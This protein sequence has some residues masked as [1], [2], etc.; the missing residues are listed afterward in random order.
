MDAQGVLL[1]HEYKI[2]IMDSELF[3]AALSSCVSSRTPKHT[4]ACSSLHTLLGLLDMVFDMFTALGFSNIH[5]VY[6]AVK[7][8]TS[9]EFKR[10]AL[11]Q[12]CH[13]SG[14]CCRACVQ[15]GD[16]CYVHPEHLKWVVCLWLCT[17]VLDVERGRRD[18]PQRH[19]STYQQAFLYVLEQLQDA[20]ETIEARLEKNN[21]FA[22]TAPRAAA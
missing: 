1:L 21:I 10:S 20:C 6:K 22:A 3:A 14:T 7:R 13:L 11:W 18:V 4:P 5:A 17:H 16:G 9:A 2:M 15:V 19:V 12:T 8:H